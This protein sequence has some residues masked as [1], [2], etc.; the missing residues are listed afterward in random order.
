MTHE[1][2]ELQP[3]TFRRDSWQ[4]LLGAPRRAADG[5]VF[6][7]LIGVSLCL[8]VASRFDPPVL[9]LVRQAV[10]DAASPVLRL[11]TGAIA[12]LL[13]ARRMIAE[14]QS[15]AD[16]RNR[17]RDENERLL[18]W[19]ARAQA[20]ERQNVAL[21][22]V[23]H[24]VEEPKLAF[25][26]ARIVSG[27]GGPFV[28]AALLDAG[29]ETGLQPGHPVMSAQGLVGRVITTGRT[30]ARILL[31]TDYNSRIPVVIG[32]SAARA[33]MQGDNGPYP[34]IAYLP[35][36]SQI[37]PG[38]DVFTSG[39]GGVFPRGLRVG[40]V[41]DVGDQL[42]IEPAARFDR[43]DYVSVLFYEQL[44]ASLLDEERSIEARAVRRPGTASPVTPSFSP[45]WPTSAEGG[46]AR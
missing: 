37:G 18:G 1:T 38:D 3:D 31:L 46:I 13:N 44:S 22:D 11:V 41:V 32:R 5:V 45:G 28:R 9:G 7:A 16:E 36:D 39:V 4:P 21:A 43:L 26:T 40:T 17:L 10:Q 24:L 6:G 30:S 25:V 14:W 12:P 29:R 15:I 8:V 23:A 34:R 2:S 33:V 19:Q 35:P 42:R 20:L 27:S